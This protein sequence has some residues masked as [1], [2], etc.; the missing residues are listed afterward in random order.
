MNRSTISDN[1]PGI[2]APVRRTLFSRKTPTGT[3]LGLSLA[4]RIAEEHGGSVRLVESSLGK[5][6]FTL[7]LMKNRPP[8]PL[9]HLTTGMASKPAVIDLPTVLKKSA[10][11]LALIEMKGL[12]P[13]ANEDSAT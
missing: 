12:E 3:G 8:L 10:T 2:P 4:R 11:E 5:T 1:G 13:R 9:D 6:V 7:S